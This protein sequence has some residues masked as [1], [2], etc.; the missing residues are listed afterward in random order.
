MHLTKVNGKFCHVQFRLSVR[1]GF[2]KCWAL[3]L[4]DRLWRSRSGDW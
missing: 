4:S 1:P 3:C 2:W